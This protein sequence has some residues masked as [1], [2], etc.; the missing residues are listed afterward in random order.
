MLLK[1]T[2]KLET[3]IEEFLDKIKQGSQCVKEC[4]VYY[5]NEDDVNFDSRIDFIKKTETEGDILRRN[6]ETRLYT[7]SLIP[8]QRGDFLG[9]LESSDN[10][11]N[12]CKEVLLQFDVE[13]PVIPRKFDKDILSLTDNSLSSVDMMISAVSSFLN[14][15]NLVREFITKSMF[16]KK[17]SLRIANKLKRDIFAYSEL[18]L[19]GKIHIRYFVYHIESIAAAAEIVC[20]RL[21]IAV[22]KHF[23]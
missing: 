6:I 18:Q 16:F 11:L 19:S 4:I 13:K 21:S 9:L 23:G 3:E 7:H 17:E 1:K 5:L 10:V 20:D 15:I 12:L 8:E 14:E 2:K 22:M